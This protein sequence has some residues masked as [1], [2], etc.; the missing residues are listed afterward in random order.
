MKSQDL[1]VLLKIASMV[2]SD[3]V[4]WTPRTNGWQDWSSLSGVPE[5]GDLLAGATRQAK[6]E[7]AERDFGVRSLAQATGVSKSQVSL[8]LR[9]CEEI[10]LLTMQHLQKP[11][12]NRRGLCEFLVYGARYVFP[13]HAGALATGIATGTAAP[14]FKRK[15]FSGTEL[16][17][18]WP[19]AYGHSH[20][21]AVTP[22]SPSVPQAVRHD[23]LLYAM[24]ALLDSLR[25]G[26]ARE[27][28]IAED[29]L[30]RI[31]QIRS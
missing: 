3:P 27:R 12:I 14:V 18:V 17:Q 7:V 4:D 5:R 19:D 15:L 28:K 24:L 29:E 1:L 23:P 8:S 2:H 20:G 16:V 9:H 11:S 10:G 26:G 31:L 13:V 22:L 30:A 21:Q 25:L 6:I